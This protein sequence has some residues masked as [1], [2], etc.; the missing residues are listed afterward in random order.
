MHGGVISI[1]SITVELR[2]EVVLGGPQVGCCGS[3]G[4][5]K[6]ANIVVLRSRR[7]WG[8]HDQ[9]RNLYERAIDRNNNFNFLRMIAASAVLVSHA[10]PISLG[11]GA[12]E[13]LEATIKLNLGTLAVLTFF[14]F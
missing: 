8:N 12:V 1:T 4:A 3:S 13:P 11:Q 7:T 6:M 2:Y 5:T 10:Y 9:V 14:N